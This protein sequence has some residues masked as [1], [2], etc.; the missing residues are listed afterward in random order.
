LTDD[1]AP[2]VDSTRPVF[3]ISVPLVTPPA[4]L[5]NPADFVRALAG[6]PASNSF[7]DRADAIHKA[8]IGSVITYADAKEIP[9]KELTAD[10]FWKAL[11]EGGEWK[12][13]PV[14]G[15]PS[16]SSSTARPAEAVESASDLPL[17]AIREAHTPAFVSPLMTKLYQESNLRLAPNRVALHPDDARVADLTKGGRAILQ[18]RMGKCMV[19]VTVDASVPV[20]TVV[21]GGSPGIQDVCGAGARA[22]VVSA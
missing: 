22:K 18:T 15:P 16:P 6:V 13:E 12:G 19:G 20:G 4:G 5:A 10:A 17:V 9:A 8:G 11:N 3:R 1:I 2:A 14:T 21:V 7:R